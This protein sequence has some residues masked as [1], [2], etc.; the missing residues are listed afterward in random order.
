MASSNARTSI[1][2]GSMTVT[3]EPRVC[4]IGFHCHLESLVAS[5]IARTSMVRGSS[6]QEQKAQLRGQLKLSPRPTEARMY[7]L[8]FCTMDTPGSK[9]L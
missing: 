3:Q 6:V 8:S 5:S 1:V 7:S 9:E 4:S 2:R